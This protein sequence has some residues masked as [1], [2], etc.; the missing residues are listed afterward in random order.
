MVRILTRVTDSILAVDDSSSSTTTT[1]SYV[2]QLETDING[3]PNAVVQVKNT[4]ASNSLKYKIDG[5]IDGSNY[6]AIVAETVLAFGVVDINLSTTGY[7]SLRIQ[8]KNN[9]SEV[10]SSCQVWVHAVNP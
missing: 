7:V 2:T 3:F 9:A 6:K 4:H 1:D 5:T 10:V 8:A